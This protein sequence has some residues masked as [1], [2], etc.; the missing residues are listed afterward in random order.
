MTEQLTVVAHLRA[1]HGQIAETKAF[2]LGLIEAT[3]TEP[4]CVEYWL[5]QDNDDPAE[6]TFYENWT[7][8]VEWDRHMELPHLQKFAQV[9]DKVFELQKLRLMTMICDPKSKR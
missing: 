3:R 6:F 7:S 9:K 5:H 2:L 1:L 8:R 4:G